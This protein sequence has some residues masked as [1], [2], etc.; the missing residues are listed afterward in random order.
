MYWKYFN[1]K[2]VKILLE[3]RYILRNDNFE[4]ICLF[5]NINV[6]QYSHLL[7]NT[8]IVVGTT[9]IRDNFEEYTIV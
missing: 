2:Y 4:I 7:H 9:K 6:N 3:I 5:L 8:K 1:N